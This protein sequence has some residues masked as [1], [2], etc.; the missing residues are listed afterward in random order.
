MKSAGAITGA[1]PTSGGAGD[2]SELERL[3]QVP[4]FLLD[5]L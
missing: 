2:E 5:V 3:K 4:V 1:E